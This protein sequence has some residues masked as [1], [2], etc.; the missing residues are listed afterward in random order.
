MK[1]LNSLLY[2]EFKLVAYYI[3]F[4]RAAAE[5]ER[6]LVTHACLLP[7][8]NM[9]NSMQILTHSAAL[10]CIIFYISQDVP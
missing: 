4:C 7:N 6:T 1:L 8:K 10:A 3:P 5:I 2:A 9:G